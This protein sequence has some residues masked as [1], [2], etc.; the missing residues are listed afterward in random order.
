MLEDDHGSVSGT[1]RYDVSLDGLRIYLQSG[2]VL[3]SDTFI[4]A[5]SVASGV[6]RVSPDDATLYVGAGAGVV[7]YDRE[8]LVETTIILSAC[9]TSRLGFRP[10]GAGLFMLADDLLC[11]VSFS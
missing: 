2:Q 6:P 7:V 1:G 8:L 9:Q 5:A 4:Q 3:R 10:N 11:W